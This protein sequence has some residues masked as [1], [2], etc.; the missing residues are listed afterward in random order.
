MVA[1]DFNHDGKIDLAVANLASND[2]SILLGKGDGTFHP[3]VNYAAGTGPVSVRAG[4]FN[5]GGN[6]DLAACADV[7][8]SVLVFLGKGDGTFRPP[9]SFPTGANCNSIAVGDID[10]DGRTDIVAATT[11]GVVVMLNSSSN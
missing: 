10:G 9:L 4:V 7:S 8:A 6:V 11:N 2:L 3:A 5:H 1:R